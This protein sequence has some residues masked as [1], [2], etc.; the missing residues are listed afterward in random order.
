MT[1]AEVAAG[2]LVAKQVM[3]SKPGAQALIAWRTADSGM[4]LRWFLERFKD[5][6]LLAGLLA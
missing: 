5:A 2:R 1:R 3:E 6:E 4:A